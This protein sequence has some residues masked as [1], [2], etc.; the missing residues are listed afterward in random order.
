M[1]G[2]KRSTGFEHL[3]KKTGILSKIDVKSSVV[4]LNQQK[5]VWAK[6]TIAALLKRQT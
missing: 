4:S 3:Q 2:I 1:R 5:D 6:T